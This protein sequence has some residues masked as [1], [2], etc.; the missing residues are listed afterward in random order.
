[1]KHKNRTGVV[2]STNPDFRYE[3]GVEKEQ[4]TPA[5]GKQDLRVMLDASHRKGK[6]VTLI[7][8]FKGL[9]DDLQQ[10][11]R[12]LKAICGSGGTVKDGEILVQ[13]DFREKVVGHLLRKGYKVKKSGG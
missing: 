8:G 4:E 5:P 10:L 12:D 9:D 6:K 7:T 1:M 2:Y 11:G 3:D 13:G